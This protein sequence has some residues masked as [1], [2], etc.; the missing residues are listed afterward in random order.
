MPG[1][2]TTITRPSIATKLAADGQSLID[3]ASGA[4]RYEKAASGGAVVTDHGPGYPLDYDAGRGLVL[5]ASANAKTLYAKAPP[6]GDLAAAPGQEIMHIGDADKDWTAM[7]AEAAV[8]ITA[9]RVMADGSWLLVVGRTNGY[10]DG[11]IEQCRIYR[12]A[13]PTDVDATWTKV[14]HQH[15]G[16]NPGP[17]SPGVRGNRFVYGDYTGRA[18]PVYAGRNLW[19][20]E[21]AG[22]HWDPIWSKTTEAAGAHFHG[23]DFDPATLDAEGNPTRIYA[24]W[25][26]GADSI[27]MQLDRPVDWEPGDGA[28]TPTILQTGAVPVQ[29]EAKVPF[30]G[31]LLV[32]GHDLFSLDPATGVY[33]RLWRPPLPT[34]TDDYA[35]YSWN[36]AYD[37]WIRS[38][39]IHSGVIYLSFCLYAPA[40]GSQD[41]VYASADGVHWVALWRDVGNNMGVR[42]TNFVAEG[43]VY[44]YRN[45][46]AGDDQV[47][48][49]PAVSPALVNALRVER[50]ETNVVVDVLNSDLVGWIVGSNNWKCNPGSNVKG[51]DGGMHGAEYL[52]SQGTS[53]FCDFYIPQYYYFCSSAGAGAPDYPVYATPAAGKRI[54]I[55]VWLRVD[56]CPADWTWFLHPND[57]GMPSTGIHWDDAVG[58]CV[59]TGKWVQLVRTGKV[60]GPPTKINTVYVRGIGTAGTFDARIDCF[61]VLYLDDWVAATAWQVGGTAR[62]DEQASVSLAGCA[63]PWSLLFGW[64]PGDGWAAAVAADGVPL[65]TIHGPAGTGKLAV[66]Y[67]PAAQTFGLWNGSDPPVQTGTVKWRHFDKLWVAISQAA[68]GVVTLR[69][70]SPVE[71]IQSADDSGI[72]S[73]GAPIDAHFG[74]DPAGTGFGFGLFHSLGVRHEAI[75]AAE[76]A[77][78]VSRPGWSW[79]RPLE[80]LAL[81]GVG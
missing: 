68:G 17:T 43:R 31:K 38:V 65:V 74:V 27:V 59:G 20:T 37:E 75:S 56:A 3:V 62:A 54:V 60:T 51:T 46:G 42:V 14:H 11:A 26:D 35:R 40:A 4:V 61:R 48:S 81:L 13:N 66:M 30:G 69:V 71:G 22:I 5:Y 79:N 45:K 76:F 63:A 70:W 23:A 80:D 16:G 25:G 58:K 44:G 34:E 7:N 49:F 28:W 9:C 6:L 8:Y 50:G 2:A 21:D 24:A 47:V 64:H 72:L 53:T 29:P 39:R 12:S 36:A 33:E 32:A 57:S 77:S 10:T 73:V 78:M 67:Y 19:Y 1:R 41:G 15:D 52:R 55:S 18:D